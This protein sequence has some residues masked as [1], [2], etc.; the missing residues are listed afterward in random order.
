MSNYRNRAMATRTGEHDLARKDP[1]AEKAPE[2]TTPEAA[3]SEGSTSTP[4]ET[5][6]DTSSTGRSASDGASA[7]S[8]ESTTE[9]GDSASE[10]A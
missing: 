8:S 1:N 3:V 9:G 10:P 4:A 7:S 5:T 6:T 2:R